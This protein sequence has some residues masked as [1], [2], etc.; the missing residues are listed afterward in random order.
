[1][2]LL[3]QAAVFTNLTPDHLHWHGS[4]KAY[5][6]AKRRLF[7]DGRRTVELA[8]LN[9]D[10]PFGRS[11]ARE[12]GERGG[13]TITYGHAQDADYRLTGCRWDA[14]ES[15]VALETPSGPLEIH[16]RL[17]GPHNAANVATAL[18]VADG[19]G[20]ARTPTIAAIAAASL[21][22]GRF[23][24]VDAGQPFEVIVDFAHSPDSLTRV[25][26]AM[27]E[28]ATAGCGQLI[29]VVGLAPSGERSTREECGRAVRA[30][31]DHLILSAWSLK[32]EPSLVALCGLLAGARQTIGAT[33]EVVLDR[34]AAIAHGLSLA[35][36]GDVVAILGR[37]P[38]TGM[39]LDA[40]SAPIAFDDREVARELLQATS[41]GGCR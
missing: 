22:P 10:D 37:G 11:L 7:I 25:L 16:A 12:I 15:R 2:E 19:L 40:H 20:L 23:E 29:A 39:T 14:R 4:M 1:V 26:A 41:S 13:R 21:P 6:Q 35:R 32:G 36:P 3:P 28:I 27:R 17:P 31:S 9:A 18:A 30:G 33:L 5:G 34:R 8:V 24:P 38:L